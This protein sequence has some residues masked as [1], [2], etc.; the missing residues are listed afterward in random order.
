M[1]AK[2]KS[3][4]IINI[5]TLMYFCLQII[6]VLKSVLIIDTQCFFYVFYVRIRTLKCTLNEFYFVSA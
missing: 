3:I 6:E 2:K 1:S 4:L 5:H